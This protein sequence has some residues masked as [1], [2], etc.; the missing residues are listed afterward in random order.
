MP[1][2]P[3]VE[4]LAKVK[5][6]NV[7]GNFEQYVVELLDHSHSSLIGEKVLLSSTSN[8]GLM[9][10]EQFYF[11][12]RIKVIPDAS[13]PFQFS[14]KEYYARR[15]IHLQSF[16]PNDI[17]P[18]RVLAQKGVDYYIYLFRN[19]LRQNIVTALP[20]SN[21]NGVILAL[22]VGD[23]TSLSKTL[24]EEY[25]VA[26][27]IHVLAV[28]GLHVGFFYLFLMLFLRFVRIKWLHVFLLVIGLVFYAGLTGF[29][30]SVIR[31][32]V[33]FFFFG[34]AKVLNRGSNSINVLFMASF[35]IL[36]IK[37][38][39]LWEPGFQLSFMAVLGIVLLY[40]P[41]SSLVKSKY[42]LVNKVYSALSVSFVAQ[43]FTAPLIIYYFHQLPVYFLLSN[44]VVVVLVQFVL[45][46]GVLVGFLGGGYS[47]LIYFTE[48]VT[49]LMNDFIG[50]VSRLPFSSLDGLWVD[51]KQVFFLYLF[52]G[53]VLLFWGKKRRF[54]SV[55]AIACLLFAVSVAWFREEK[56]R[57]ENYLA[58]HKSRGKLVI[59]ELR[60]TSCKLFFASNDLDEDKLRQDF[61]AYFANRNIK[62]L[63]LLKLDTVLVTGNKTIG[64]MR[65]ENELFFD[66]NVLQNKYSFNV[67]KRDG[68]EVF[69]SKDK[70]SLVIRR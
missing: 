41:V 8:L 68:E 31:A 24:K 48:Y 17:K 65:T 49:I 27:V 70:K 13:I 40:E 58:F 19:Y 11:R 61:H 16:A 59:E 30:P 62:E 7:Y 9:P 43:L 22:V 45:L 69:T 1:E 25:K 38:L 64:L 33:M 60:G 37:P 57:N 50:L 5:S 10:G 47:A 20:N 42:W 44:L 52:I 66:L 6:V 26:G 34:L 15:G 55:L 63:E 3:S 36:L 54:F 35:F 12:S 39:L 67:R 14:F 29:S 51:E 4:F 2:Y 53:S 21:V 32:S 28:S 46:M 23:K 56:F 18:K